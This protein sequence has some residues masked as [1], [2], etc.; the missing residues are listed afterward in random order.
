LLTICCI[1]LKNKYIHKFHSTTF[2]G[3]GTSFTSTKAEL[4]WVP[5]FY[6]M[7]DE[8]IS[9]LL[10]M[11]LSA[12]EFS[13]FKKDFKFTMMCQSCLSHSKMFEW[14]FFA[15]VVWQNLECQ[16]PD[17]LN[18]TQKKTKWDHCKGISEKRRAVHRDQGTTDTS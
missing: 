3:W 16:H 6:I 14:Y 12:I 5:I 10:V 9:L 8:V 2:V 11:L 7:S 13:Y 4:F 15:E 17:H 1:M 18:A